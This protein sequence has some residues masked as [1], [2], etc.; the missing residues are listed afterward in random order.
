MAA[1][2]SLQIKALTPTTRAAVILLQ[3][4]TDGHLLSLLYPEFLAAALLEFGEVVHKT[5]IF[6]FHRR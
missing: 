4:A 3:A 5:V 6:N 2:A 1:S